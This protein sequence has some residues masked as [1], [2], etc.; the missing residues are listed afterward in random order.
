MIFHLILYLTVAMCFISSVWI[1]QSSRKLTPGLIRDLFKY[2]LWIGI[3]GFLYT[4]WIF[5]LG[6]GLIHMA[7][8]S[9]LIQSTAIAIAALFMIISRAAICM[10]STRH[11]LPSNLKSK[12]I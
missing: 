4:A 2:L 7:D 1:Y 5:C 11:P 8:P 6:T 12:S 10:V 9:L 3:W